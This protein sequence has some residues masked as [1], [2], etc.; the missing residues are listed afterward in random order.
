MV[1][2]SESHASHQTV[3]FGIAYGLTSRGLAEQLKCS[4][5]QVRQKR[6]EVGGGSSWCPIGAVVTCGNIFPAILSSGDAETVLA[7]GNGASSPHLNMWW[8]WCEKA[9]NKEH[10]PSIGCNFKEGWR[11]PYHQMHPKRS[12]ILYT[13]TCIRT[14]L[15][16]C[17][18][19]SR[20]CNIE[21]LELSVLT[22]Q[23]FRRFECLSLEFRILPERACTEES[24]TGTPKWV[25][26][27]S[28]Y[29]WKFV[30]VKLYEQG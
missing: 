1:I 7:D 14:M 4:Q 5:T 15:L 8:K 13:S 30:L 27:D 26:Y 22:S 18:L 21:M 29:P 20:L 28:K 6:W 9:P 10:F 11:R 23:N 24:G 19:C 2:F 25:L 3:N 16:L 17:N 12:R